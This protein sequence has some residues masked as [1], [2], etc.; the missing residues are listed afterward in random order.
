MM[1][2]AKR[3]REELKSRQIYCATSSRCVSFPGKLVAKRVNFAGTYN[4]MSEEA[5]EWDSPL[6]LQASPLL[7]KS[8]LLPCPF[9]LF[10]VGV[11]SW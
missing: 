7:F 1:R 3:V 6:T 8:S 9:F 5:R 2:M 10:P 4:C 11:A